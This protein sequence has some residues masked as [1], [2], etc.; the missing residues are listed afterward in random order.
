MKHT[1]SFNRNIYGGKRQNKGITKY[2]KYT[3]LAERLKAE[4]K[5][6]EDYRNRVKNQLPQNIYKIN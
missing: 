6:Y 2:G 3:T 4:C 5:S 1:S